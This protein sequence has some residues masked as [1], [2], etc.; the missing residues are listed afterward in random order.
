M[1]RRLHKLPESDKDHS[2]N[3]KNDNVNKIPLKELLK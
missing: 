3:I 1:Y 2:P